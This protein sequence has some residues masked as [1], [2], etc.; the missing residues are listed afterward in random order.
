M[1]TVDAP[2]EIPLRERLAAVKRQ[3]L[4]MLAA[5]A[6]GAIASVALALGLPPTYRADATILIEQQEIP[7]DLV[8]STVTSFADQR[9]QV[10]SQRVMTSQNLMR[11]VERYDLYPKMRERRAREEVVARMRRDVAMKMISANVIDPQ[12]GRP[13]QATIAFTLGY[14][15]PSPELAVKVANE[16]TTLY[17]NENLTARTT[18]AQ[19]TTAFLRDEGTRLAADIERLAA[20]LAEF[21]TKHAGALPERTQ[22]NLQLLDRTEMALRDVDRRVESLDAQRTLLLAQLAQMSPTSQVYAESGERILSPA[23][24]LRTLRSQL[25]ALKARY[26]ADHPDV[27]RVEREVAGLEAVVGADDDA[28]DLLRRLDEARG[29]LGAARER[30]S[31]DHP[32]VQRLARVVDALEA[33]L[34]D[35]KSVERVRRARE[36][37]DNPAYL[38]VRT[39]LRLVEQ[40]R[41]AALREAEALRAQRGEYERRMAT[42]P[43]VEK[44]YR[45]LATEYQSAQT[46]Y[47][48]VRAKQME[49]TLGQNLEAER[50]GERFTLIEPPLPPDEPV[51]PNRPVVLLLGLLASALLAA[52]IGV[53]RE[54]LDGTVRGAGELARLV[55]VPPLVTVPLVLTSDERARR[56]RALRYSWVGAFGALALSVAIVHLWVRPLDVVLAIAMRRL[57]LA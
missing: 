46:K 25:A 39:Q 19:Q 50:K 38:Q 20:Q 17:L 1:N 29:Q 4:P 28:N 5:L 43:D 7:Q 49:A 8:R 3:R 33:A 55:D 22:L 37:A 15:S 27:L 51:S 23:D 26:A 11:I 16:L 36:G 18:A 2:I 12:S 53:V 6:C 57:G 44:A 14:Q 45:Q 40:D 34:R 54:I 13:M 52:G 47:Q 32:D 41:E 56:L 21:Q 48:E 35:S 24:R 9:I 42:A 10:I 30:Y 31:S